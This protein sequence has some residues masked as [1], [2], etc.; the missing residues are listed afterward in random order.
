[1]LI[2]I[3]DTHRHS[4]AVVVKFVG[5]Q[6][7]AVMQRHLAQ[8]VNVQQKRREQHS[9]P[10]S[11]PYL[12]RLRYSGPCPAESTSSMETATA[13]HM[14]GLHVLQLIRHS[15]T[16]RYLASFPVHQDYQ[17]LLTSAVV[18]LQASTH[19]CHFFHLMHGHMQQLQSGN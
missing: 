5:M 15:T 1:M 10:N 7:S 2:R 17:H 12:L 3:C 6:F 19:W 4:A 11:L 8:D 16:A 18:L 9:V 14:A 13:D